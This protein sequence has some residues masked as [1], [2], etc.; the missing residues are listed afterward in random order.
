MSVNNKIIGEWESDTISILG[1]L[2]IA[3]VVNYKPDG[4]LVMTILFKNPI[5]RA[6]A[7]LY[8]LSYKGR[9][10]L[11]SEAGVITSQMD[12]S[13]MY[14]TRFFDQILKTF[15]IQISADELYS[16]IMGAILNLGGED[17]ARM[18]ND[19]QIRFNRGNFRR[20]R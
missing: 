4:A 8:D 7:S 3:S 6:G 9:W 10:W 18:I 2:N 12:G 13:S 11:G 15:R 5:L 17:S 14:P 1:V 20:R 19:N 16:K